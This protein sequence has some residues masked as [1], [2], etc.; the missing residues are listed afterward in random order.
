MIWSYK[1]DLAIFPENLY[2]LQISV[3]HFNNY[4]IKYILPDAESC[5]WQDATQKK[6]MQYGAAKLLPFLCPG[7]VKNMENERIFTFQAF[8]KKAN[9]L[10]SFDD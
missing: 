4:V 1:A 3:R 10:A 5:E 7:P 6:I 8:V 2:S 9:H